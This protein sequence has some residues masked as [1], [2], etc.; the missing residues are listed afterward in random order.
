LVQLK[1]SLHALDTANSDEG[2]GHPS[3]ELVQFLI[4]RSVKLDGLRAH[5][6]LDG[7]SC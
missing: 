2:P 5:R 4:S 1:A 7:Q 6:I 3:Y